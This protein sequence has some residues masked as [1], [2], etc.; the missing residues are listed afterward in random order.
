MAITL[1]VLKTRVKARLEPEST[2]PTINSLHDD[3]WARWAAALA[4]KVV[5]FVENF[6]V[7]TSKYKVEL[8][9]DRSFAWWDSTTFASTPTANRPIGV[10]ATD[11][12]YIKPTTDKSSVAITAGYCDYFKKHPDIDGSNG[13]LFSAIA[14]KVLEDLVFKQALEATEDLVVE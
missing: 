10:V 1:A 2:A 12:I 3:Q 8:L 9:D 7:T 6:K 4:Q 11:K 14:D 13:T 5:A